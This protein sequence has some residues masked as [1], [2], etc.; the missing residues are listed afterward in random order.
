MRLLIQKMNW[1]SKD[2]TSL[3]LL[4]IGSATG[5]FLDEARIV[6]FATQG[7]EISKEASRY[8]KENLHLNVWEGGFLDFPETEKWDAIVSFFTLEHIPEIQALWEKLERMVTPGGA[9]LIAIPSFNGP[10]FQTNPEE[11]FRTHPSDHFFDYDPRSIQKI[12][13]E[14]DF[15]VVFCMPLS[16]HPKRDQG[17]K[18]KMPRLFYKWIS[19]NTCYGDTMQILAK[20]KK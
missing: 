14:I 20:K 1:K 5:I 9:I 13:K 19:K 8:A 3:K 12:L 18:G 6:G 2:L 4:E 15:E 16:F 10:S 17:W 7:I 11:W